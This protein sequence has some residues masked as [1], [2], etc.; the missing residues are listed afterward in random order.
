MFDFLFDNFFIVITVVVVIVVRIVNARLKRNNDES[1]ENRTSNR[2]SF[3]D[4]EKDD[5]PSS[6]LGHWE[7]EKHAPA[8]SAKPRH[9]A[10][11]S[12]PLSRRD[13][14]P[15]TPA[16]NNAAAV[17]HAPAA[18]TQKP[19]TQ[20]DIPKTPFPQNLDYLPAFKKAIILSE[21]LSPPKALREE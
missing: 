8:Y 11:A 3:F 7:T 18:S 17:S 14:E 16:I 2:S 21:I 1:A 15:L 4:E 6:L 10:S 19:V 5:E 13:L 9:R 20:N 12:Q